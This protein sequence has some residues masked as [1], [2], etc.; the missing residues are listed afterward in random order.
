MAEERR[1][2]IGECGPVLPEQ[3]SR[4]GG[5]LVGT[6]RKVDLKCFPQN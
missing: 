4:E 3:S 6:M 2:R 5:I 1:D